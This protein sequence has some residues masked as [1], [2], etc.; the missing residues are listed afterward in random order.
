MCGHL[1]GLKEDFELFGESQRSWLSSYLFGVL[2]SSLANCLPFDKSKLYDFETN[3]S[4]AAN[5]VRLKNSSEIIE[6]HLT[7]WLFG[8]AGKRRWYKHDADIS[9]K[10]KKLYA[11]L[12][13][14]LLAS[15][16][17]NAGGELRGVYSS[18]FNRKM[19]RWAS[20]FSRFKRKLRMGS[21]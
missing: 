2:G 18:P 10:Q 4:C 8:Q 14:K 19:N 1:D 16:F 7:Q 20:K 13:E 9:L 12:N 15:R 21:R 6:Q 5:T 17:M 3:A 11:I